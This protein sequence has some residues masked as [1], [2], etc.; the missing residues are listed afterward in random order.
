M[1]TVLASY[2]VVEVVR[3]ALLDN[4]D[5][6]ALVA[7]RV[8]GAYPEQADASEATFPVVVLLQ[9]GGSMRRF[10]RLEDLSLDVVCLSQASPGAAAALYDAVTAVLQIERLTFSDAA[11]AGSERVA[12][13]E[14]V[15]RPG[16]IR[17]EGLRAW[18]FSGRWLARALW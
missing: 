15:A 6:S 1:S 8:L 16:S 7:D 11:A 9:R 3:R 13:C 2:G 18:A 5:V 12:V 14:E 10:A 4:S 17:D